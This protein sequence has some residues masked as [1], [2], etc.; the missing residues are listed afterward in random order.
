MKKIIKHLFTIC[1]SMLLIIA[2]T[3]N[4]YESPNNNNGRILSFNSANT[5]F[6]DQTTKVRVNSDTINFQ[7]LS[8]GVTSRKWTFPESMV[9]ILGSTNNTTTDLQN[10]NV[11]F[12]KPG[13]IDVMLE[14]EFEGP[15]TDD[16]NMSVTSFEAL[17]QIIAGLS[18]TLPFDGETFIIEA[19]EETTFTN[20]S[21]ERNNAEWKVI[22]LTKEK[23]EDLIE[24]VDLTFR[25]RSLGTYSVRLRAFDNDPPSSDNLTILVKV[26]PSS[27][28]LL[29]DPIVAENE[30]GE[31][32]IQYSRDL[33][34]NTLDPITNF[35]LTID[36]AAAPIESVK[37]DPENPARIIVKPTINIKNTQT[38]T[39]T[40]NAVALISEDEFDAPSL[41][42]TE[43]SLFSPNIFLKDPT[44]EKEPML[45][46]EP[47]TGSNIAGVVRALVDPGPGNDSNTAMSITVNKDNAFIMKITDGIEF[48]AG[49]KISLQF[50]YL[51]PETWANNG[52]WN[53]RM[54]G[55]T[56]S[57]D[58]R[59]F[60][61]TC[62]G[63]I[64][65]GTWQTITIPLVG[66]GGAGSIVKESGK[67]N[68]FL[69]IIAR[70]SE[71]TEILFDN[72]VIKNV[73]Q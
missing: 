9:D 26:I 41:A 50:D 52:E 28:P 45:Q 34:I 69:Q 29:V 32:I 25:F 30:V 55:S 1:I 21:S 44:F 40:Y 42:E 47:P 65:D 37:I 10:F 22:N 39:L 8:L 58:F 14:P 16:Q 35:A 54:F 4:E 6:A 31:I 18:T 23:E 49:N 46:F 7:D 17:P 48:T 73:E 61:G 36:G 63:L 51:L 3:T 27:K 24:T 33:N 56:F 20:T 67:V 19:G 66:S 57:D 43:V 11:V 60:Y 64:A 5:A 62:C 53:T 71:T 15:V 2:C 12:R 72:F 59:T 38:A 70:S 13:N 68:F